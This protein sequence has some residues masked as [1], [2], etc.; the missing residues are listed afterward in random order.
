ML[1]MLRQARAVRAVVRR[2]GVHRVMLLLNLVQLPL[3]RA[4]TLVLRPVRRDPSLV[5]FGAPLDR[6]SDNAAYLFL[7]MSEHPTRLRPVW[8]TG[9]QDL[10]RRL[11]AHGYRAEM[12]WRWAGVRTAMSAGTFV[13]SGYES[14]INHWLAPG[15]VRLCLWHGLPIKRVEGGVAAAAAD[16]TLLGRLQRLGQEPPPDYLLTPSDFVRT[17]FSQWFGVPVERCLEHGYPR[18]DHLLNDPR[19]PPAAMV[20]HDDIWRRLN[21]ASR[22][23]GLFLTWRDDATDDAVDRELVHRLTETCARSSAVLAY[24]A[25]YNVAAADVSSEACVVIP[26]DADLHAYLGLCDVLITDYSS[27]SADF[28]LLRRPV[29]YFMPD[30][31]SYTLRR[32]L[33]VDPMQ[34]PGTVTQDPETLLLTLAR[35]LGGP[36]HAWDPEDERFLRTL[37]N[38]YDGHAC[39]AIAEALERLAAG[40]AN[41]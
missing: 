4:L 26:A 33:N 29:V 23:V 7:H 12:R 3:R 20:W 21:S 14:D 1:T 36:A 11:R 35:V 17:S 18:N 31:E 22:V 32:G 16:G 13:Y 6:F 28:L 34:L 24:K 9:S 40:V 38:G 5:V 10:V 19:K 2:I 30:L 8:I 27:I 25:H 41:G 37:W 15:A 39:A